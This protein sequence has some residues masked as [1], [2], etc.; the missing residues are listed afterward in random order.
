MEEMTAIK[1]TKPSL[2]DQ[3]IYTKGLEKLA[4]AAGRHEPREKREASG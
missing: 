1:N 4:D 2:G 3:R